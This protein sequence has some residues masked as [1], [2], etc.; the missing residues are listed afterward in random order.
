MKH[1]LKIILGPTAHETVV[2]VDDQPIGLIQDIKFH[3]NV[4][5]TATEIEII[6]PNM[7]PF[8]DTNV[9]MC[10]ILEDALEELK[11]VPHVKVTLKDIEFNK[12]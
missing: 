2:Y 9:H 6:F 5:D 7:F 8:S 11:K 12:A 4:D 3:A 10:M 1:E